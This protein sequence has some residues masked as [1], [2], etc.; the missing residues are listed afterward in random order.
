MAMRIAIAAKKEEKAL[1]L[2]F[3]ASQIMCLAELLKQEQ[4]LRSV[5]IYGKALSMPVVIGELSSVNERG[6]YQGLTL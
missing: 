4:N 1:S 3:E 5:S 2:F 6:C